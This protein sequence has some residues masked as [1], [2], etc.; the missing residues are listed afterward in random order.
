MPKKR[1]VRIPSI[2]LNEQQSQAVH[3]NEGPIIITA[4]PGSGKCVSGDTLVTTSTG[5]RP[6]KDCSDINWVPS[7]D[8]T[9]YTINQEHARWYYMGEKE[10]ITCRTDSGI[11][12]TGTP[13]HPVLV[14]DGNFTWKRLDCL[15]PGD[16]TLL[17][18]GHSLNTG[19]RRGSN[20]EAYLLGLL[21]GDGWVS[22]RS[23]TIAWSRGGNYLPD[24]YYSL[25][26]NLW[27]AI[28]TEYEKQSS[29][30]VTHEVHSKRIYDYLKSIDYPVDKVAAGKYIPP[31]IFQATTSERIAFLQG[32]FDTDGSCGSRGIEITSASKKLIQ[33]TQQLLI[34]LSIVPTLSEKFASGYD[35]SYW[36]LTIS[37]EHARTF[38]KYVGFLYEKDKQRNLEQLVDRQT[39]PNKGCYPYTRK[40]F[41]DLRNWFK[42]NNKWNGKKQNIIKHNNEE[43]SIKHYIRGS[44]KP[45]RK[46]LLNIY[47]EL[48]GG[49]THPNGLESAKTLHLM[50]ALYPD[51]IVS[52][53]SGPT[54]PVYDLTVPRTHN[55]IANGIVS[56]NT[57]VLVE[58]IA[59]IIHD[60]T[61]Q[62]DRIL[63]TTFTKKAAGEMNE[64]LQAKRIDTD[65]MSVQTTH[66][67]CWRIIRQSKQFAG[68]KVDDTDRAQIFLKMILGYKGLNWIGSDQSL[69]ATFIAHCRNHLITPD[70]SVSLLQDEWAD[71]RYKLAYDSYDQMLRDE[72]L[73][74]F[75]DMLYHGVRLLQSDEKILTREQAKYQYVM[76]DEAQDSN[77]A[78]TVLA[79]Q[80]AAP[81]FNLMIV[82]DDDQGIYKFRGAI[83]EYMINFQ[84]TYQAHL[85]ELNINYR[86]PPS[87]VQAARAC[88]EHNTNRLPKE[89]VAN[90]TDRVDII[91]RP[92]ET[93]DD[94]A[95]HVAQ[96]VQA[97]AT[98][99][100]NYG[101]MIVL[102]RTNAQ[103]RAIEEVFIEQEI[104]FIVLGAVSFYE[105]KEI[106]R[107]LAYLR[108]ACDPRDVEYGEI[109]LRS[110]YRKTSARAH[111]FIAHATRST[112]SYVDATDQAIDQH[113]I[114]P[115]CVPKVVDWVDL[116]RRIDCS[117]PPASTLQMIVDE[118]DYLNWLVQE[119][120]S[121]SL[122]SNRA[123]N[124]NELIGSASRF[125]TASQFIRYVDKQIKLRKRNQRKTGE[126]RVQVMSCHKSK[127]LE[128]HAVFVI[129]CNE[130]IFPHARG[131][132]EEERRLFYVAI[133][134]A[135]GHL[136]LTSINSMIDD[137]KQVAGLP[138]RFIEEAGINKH[139]TEEK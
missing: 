11:E 61:V 43:I 115:S 111:Q 89:L 69:V 114:H 51:P 19:I 46:Q 85:I 92:T 72:R 78:Q 79:H 118:T 64:R 80:V 83:P 97:L 113:L 57:R 95:R 104:P 38:K 7:V 62:P 131:E 74:T 2:R 77:Y 39:N 136:M 120:G 23:Y 65:R 127:G 54:I 22:H 27:G 48:C 98:D 135:K 35:Q 86:C 88:I 134:R 117:A 130:G 15:K 21:I 36:K 106:K 52:V 41:S 112:G 132:E 25:M 31:W 5:V 124:V 67:Y 4:G 33:Q 32:Y 12:L 75:D 42:R 128:A 108:V 81:E 93:S 29:E 122:E 26:N 55:F 49:I 40:L 76:V 91:Y 110:P 59:R 119:D 10:T 87:I 70:D 28:P 116:M 50:I 63:A 94:E 53:E 138:S 68:W 129:G 30:S 105:R 139:L 13:E 123:L 24:I 18:P 99:G 60:R 17:F 101:T 9:D 82:G 73:V 103:S 133:T 84:E 44:R 109:A 96:E 107:L 58:R 71:V 14:W 1:R 8:L 102:M 3:W 16:C 47:E 6:I 125:E 34:G 45:S 100:I 20:E 37:G 66:S 137:G 126:S 90:R 56:H 121:D